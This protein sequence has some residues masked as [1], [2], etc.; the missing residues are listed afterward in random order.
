VH[1]IRNMLACL[2]LL[3]ASVSVGQAA[4]WTMEGGRVPSPKK[5]A[6]LIA[7]LHSDAAK[8]K[9]ADACKDLAVYG[10]DKAV[11]ELGKLLADEQLASWARIALEA[12]PGLAS[13]E[14]LRKG[15]DSLKGNLLVGAINSIGV[16]RDVSAAKALAGKLGDQDVAVASAA[17]VALGHIGNAD[18]AKSL[19]S[20]LASTSGS[21][22]SAVAEGLV[23]CAE[24]ALAAGHAAEAVAIYDDVRKADV[25]KQRILEAT[26]GAILARRDEGIPLLIEQLKSD[27]KKMFRMALGL[28][29]AFP[30]TQVDQ[31]LAAEID[32]ATPEHAA[33]VIGAM[34]DRKATVLVAALLNAATR[35][36]T[37]VRVAAIAALGRAGNDSCVAPLLGF[38][39]ESD[40]ELSKTAKSA[41][42]ELQA[43]NVDEHLVERLHGTPNGPMYPLLIEVV[44]ERR[45]KAV[46]DLVKALESSDDVVR[47]AALKALGTTVPA[48]KLS[49]L[50]SQVVTPKHEQDTA[51]AEKALKAACVRMADR[52]ACAKELAA[53]MERSSVP[54]K[55]ALLKIVGAVGGTEALTTVGTAAKANDSEVQDASSRLLGE[56]MTI[57]AAPVLLD[58]AKTAPGDKYRVR[59]LR[60]YIRIARQFAMPEPQRVEMCESAMKAAVQPAEQKLVLDILKLKK[61]ESPA[62]LQ[63]A[64]KFTKDF[65]KLNHEA[66]QAAVFIARDLGD[67][68]H[69][70]TADEVKEILSHARLEKVKLEIVSAEYGAP[71]KQKDVTQ[72]VQKAATD[73]QLI[74]LPSP[75]YVAAFGGDPAPGTQK[76]LK[77]QY[78]INGKA[79]D[80]TFGENAL[81]ILPMP[82]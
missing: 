9:K 19:Q 65:P 8:A 31:A 58:L 59:A 64:A 24:R 15:V 57:D 12:I 80:A 30:G 1:P 5:E 82:R 36:P 25:S 27:D 47:V 50:I 11:A 16:R 38:A 7:V 3:L 76:Q 42:I 26:R 68:K 43:P 73:L 45:I 34:A 62:T 77:I 4:G 60:G 37:E 40:S 39:L 44:G 54:T 72:A 6:D 78:R 63:L 18:A 28:A 46:E 67:E 21:I 66:S 20:A 32:H 51:E 53:A 56:W 41:L 70:G 81:I 22:R 75:S 2:T 17:A 33:L 71:G 74:S 14:A 13:D 10:S 79:D 61:Y 49:V 55:I 52:E 69:S 23:L 29:R 35:G 48:D